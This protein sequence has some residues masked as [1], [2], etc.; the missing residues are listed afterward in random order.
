MKSWYCFALTL[1]SLASAFVLGIELAWSGN[2][3][4]LVPIVTNCFLCGEVAV[5]AFCGR[6]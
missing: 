5:P 6:Q 4:L 1:M 2:P 3:W